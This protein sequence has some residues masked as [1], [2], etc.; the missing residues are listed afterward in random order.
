MLLSFYLRDSLAGR[1]SDTDL[2]S[3]ASAKEDLHGRTR[4]FSSLKYLALPPSP[5]FSRR[6]A[7]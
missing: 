5:K 3:V 7:R 2:S 6:V 4:I 1:I